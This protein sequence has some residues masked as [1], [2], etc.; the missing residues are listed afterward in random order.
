M[1]CDEERL[2]EEKFFLQEKKKMDGYNPVGDKVTWHL[3]DV[4][5]S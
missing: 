3:H 2:E 1:E 4:G 5:Q